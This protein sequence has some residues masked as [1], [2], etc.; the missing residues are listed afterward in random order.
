MKNK[1]ISEFLYGIQSG[2]PICIGY[3]PAAIA[4]GLV[5]KDAGLVFT[6]TALFSITNFAGASQFFAVNLIASGALLS[7]V[8]V[9]VLLVN[10]RYLLM[11]ASLAPRLESRSP[12]IRALLAFGNTDEVF[13][14]ASAQQ[15]MVST[16]FFVGL[17]TISWAGWVSGTITGFLAGSI[18]P[19]FLQRS[20]GITLYGMF[21]ALLVSDIKRTHMFV[22]IAVLSGALNSIAVL[23]FEISTGWAFVSSMTVASV[24]GAIILSSRERST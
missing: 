3:F 7:E 18:L 24:V 15:G 20:V 1:K 17:S 12:F 4:F 8:A 5:A 19:S 21:T 11:S 13:T 16:P 9:G 10:L 23:V 6:E 2:I 22:L 14:V